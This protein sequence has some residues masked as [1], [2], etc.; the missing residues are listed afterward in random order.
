[1]PPR[2]SP[3]PADR[4]RPARRLRPVPAGYDLAPLPIHVPPR[5]GEA[6]VS[7]LRRVSLR[8]DVPARTLLKVAGTQKPVTGTSKVTARLANNRALLDRLGLTTEQARRL[9]A[10][11]PM[12]AALDD[13]LT[14]MRRRWA[15]PPRWSRYCPACLAD[16]D[17]HWP[18]DWHSPLSLL[19]LRHAVFL[20][21]L[22][23]GCDQPPLVSPAWLSQ[24]LELWRCPTRL[25]RRRRNVGRAVNPWCEF[26][27]RT[28][29]T[30]PAPDDVVRAQR[31]LVGWSAGPSEPATACGLT[32][33]RRIGFHAFVDLVDA[34]LGGTDGTVLQLADPPQ[35]AADSFLAAAHILTHRSLDDAAPAAGRLLRYDGPHAPIRP[36]WRIESHPHSPLLAA[37]Q[38]HSVRDQLGPADQLTFRTSHPVARYPAT[39][40]PETRSR[41]RLPEHRILR[42]ER[43]DTWF[44]QVVWPDVIPG[45]VG[46]PAAAPLRR[47]C[48]AMALA[49]LGSGRSWAEIADTL[50]LP[51]TLP[52]SI[53]PVLQSWVRA[54]TWPL[55]LAALD[56]LLT[57]LQ[58]DPPPINYPLRR[59]L[60]RD[61]DLV[62]RALAATARTHPSPLPARHLNR[63][64]WELFTGGDIGYAS[65]PFA[66]DAG[67][68]DYRAFRRD[69]A[70]SRDRD[71]PRLQSAHNEL[72]RMVRS[73]LGPLVWTPRR[74]HTLTTDI[75]GVQIITSD[76]P[77]RRDWPG[78]SPF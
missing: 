53:G 76:P 38:L 33:T 37:V 32:I 16:P 46:G 10:A 70:D 4:R 7:W 57:R 45:A 66:L 27:L 60:G 12:L 22:C 6:V 69:A 26:N 41:L 14:T 15:P 75:D 9:L 56:T 68:S 72:I 65:A 2:P 24:P 59:E 51:A 8:Y 67:S 21:N 18:G 34:S 50:S 25:I 62:D 3:A 11:P 13:Y 78:F 52:N 28:V 48:L 74:P 39:L 55:T 43:D 40:T 64:F 63:V 44:P 19:C 35:Q 23:P 31:L 29:A 77:P 17:P 1:M 42:P 61:P 30:Q 5:D 36:A 20:V 49:K 71:R 47:A 54:G 73:P 58:A